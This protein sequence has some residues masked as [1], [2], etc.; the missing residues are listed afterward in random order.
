MEQNAIEE[1]N[2]LDQL[3]MQGGL[4]VPYSKNYILLLDKVCRTFID[5]KLDFDVFADFS[6]ELYEKWL[7]RR[8]EKLYSGV[9]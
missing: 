1:N 6:F 4:I 3:L 9:N 8:I 5:E 7:S 2:V